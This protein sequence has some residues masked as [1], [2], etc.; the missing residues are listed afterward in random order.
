MLSDFGV[1]RKPMVA[2]GYFGRSL[3]HEAMVNS[4]AHNVSRATLAFVFHGF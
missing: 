4:G 3:N 1:V 2:Q